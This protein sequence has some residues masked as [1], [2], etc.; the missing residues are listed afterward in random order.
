M[1]EMF[2]QGSVRENSVRMSRPKEALGAKIGC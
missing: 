2:E 1:A